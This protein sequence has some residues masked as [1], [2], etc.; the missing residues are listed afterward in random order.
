MTPEAKTPAASAKADGGDQAGERPD[1]IPPPGAITRPCYLVQE[2]WLHEV[3]QNPGLGNA[4]FVAAYAISSLLRREGEHARSTLEA[5][6][7]V[8]A[9]RS[10]RG[11]STKCIR[12]SLL[13]LES[14]GHL[15]V[16]R[17]QAHGRGHFHR[18]A[19]IL[20]GSAA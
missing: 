6:G 4:A 7:A 16:D 8:V 9:L 13:S 14:S 17:S 18:Y 3:C 19:L 1:H 20:K 15:W 11:E 5:I 12:R 10:R 2:Y